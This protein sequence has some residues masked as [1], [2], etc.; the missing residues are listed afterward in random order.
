[1]A[2]RHQI[3]L[4]HEVVIQRQDFFF[5][6]SGKALFP[7]THPLAGNGPEEP[8]RVHAESLIYSFL[9]NKRFF[10]KMGDICPEVCLVAIQYATVD[11]GRLT[12]T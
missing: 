8:Q 7:R 3:K 12:S 2:A 11:F 1:M 5:Q 4:C 9:F 6:T 10:F